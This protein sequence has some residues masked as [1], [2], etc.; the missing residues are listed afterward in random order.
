MVRCALE[1]RVDYLALI[2]DDEVPEGMWLKEL[3]LAM[4]H[5]EADIVAG[6]VLPHFE[7]RVPHWVIAGEFF[8]R[9]RLATGTLL[10]RTRSGNVLMRADVFER[11]GRLF[12][13]RLL[14]LGEDTEFFFHA[15]RAGCTIIWANDAIVHEWI[16]ESRTRVK[17]LLKRSYSV[18]MFWRQF[19]SDRLA[20]RRQAFRGLLKGAILLPCSP[21]SRAGGRGQGSSALAT[22]VGY[23]A[24]GARLRVDGHQRTHDR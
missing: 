12:D 6:P 4:T 1:R 10:D 9:P 16:P 23:F 21:L 15:A 2:D 22:G 8:R 3:W 7:G 20:T 18:G 17:W 13:E 24:G 14:L 11:T 19:T 5:Y